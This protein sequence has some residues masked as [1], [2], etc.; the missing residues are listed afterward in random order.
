MVA[1]Q[2]AQKK[3]AKERRADA[4][5]RKVVEEPGE[6]RKSSRERKEVNYAEESFFP[7]GVRAERQL[8]VP[9][10]LKL[11]LATAE[12]LRA[13]ASGMA[14]NATAGSGATPAKKRGPVDSG[15]GVRVQV[16]GRAGLGRCRSRSCIECARSPAAEA[17]AGA[18]RLGAN[19]N[20]HPADGSP[21][22]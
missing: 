21:W 4:K 12:E 2:Q 17:C 1:T 11:D 20:G 10:A 16:R 7:K 14:A 18:A 5:K 9:D 8:V 6:Q 13:K 3:E 15:K 22:H 19:S